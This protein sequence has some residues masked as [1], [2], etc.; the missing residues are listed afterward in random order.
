MVN[1]DPTALGLEFGG[2]AAIGAL[3]GFAAKKIAKLIAVIIGVQLVIF[4]Y[5]E[6]QGILIVDWGALSN[7]LIKT[8]EHADPTYLESLI[9]TMSVG[10]G[11]TAGFLIGFR[12]G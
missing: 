10:V 5:L 3:M 7:G 6:S 8:S 9:S 2:G 1:I 12:R 4:R 11:F